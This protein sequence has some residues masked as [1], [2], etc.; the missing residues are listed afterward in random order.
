[1][2]HHTAALIVKKEEWREADWRVTAF[3]DHFGKIR[4]LAQGARKH[5]AKLQ[6]HLEPG[7]ITDASFVIGRNGYRLT[8]ARLRSFPA[9]SRNS[10]AKLRALSAILFLLDANLLEEREGAG[11]LFA[12][13]SGV[14]ARLEQP[15]ETPPPGR[16]AAWFQ[17]RLWDFLGILPAAGSPEAGR[18]K[19]LLMLGR[20]SLETIGAAALE[21]AALGPELSWFGAKLGRFDRS[22]I[23]CYNVV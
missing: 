8:G 4:L 13:A 18:M 1:M 16:L 3:T 20:E 7:S 21:D 2:M 19:S 17:V 22:I 11:E 9:V 10:P 5:G 14:I 6:G 15:G 12:I 23:Y